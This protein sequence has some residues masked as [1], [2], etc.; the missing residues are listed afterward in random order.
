MRSDKPR[1]HG[2]VAITAIARPEGGLDVE[3]SFP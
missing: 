1:A 3:V 2:L